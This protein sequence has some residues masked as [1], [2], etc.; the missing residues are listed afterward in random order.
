MGRP[1]PRTSTPAS[2]MP[3]PLPRTFST[4][5]HRGAHMRRL[6]ALSFVTILLAGCLGTDPM[7]EASADQI[8]IDS[9]RPAPT[10]GEVVTGPAVGPDLNATTAALPRLV[11][12][13]WW[14]IKYTSDFASVAGATDFVRV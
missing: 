11:E 2:K 12:G 1:R 10:Y 6:L 14:R 5:S 4:A 13:E 3:R 8:V 7:P 9:D